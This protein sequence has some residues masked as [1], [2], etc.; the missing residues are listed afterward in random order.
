MANDFEV[1][2]SCDDTNHRQELNFGRMAIELDEFVNEVSL[3]LSVI[4]R[5]LGQAPEVRTPP[6]PDVTPQN[7]PVPKRTPLADRLPSRGSA[8]PEERGTVKPSQTSDSRIQAI[9][10]RLARVNPGRIGDGRG[11]R[12]NE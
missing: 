11:A 1:H 5:Q 9:R 8:P 12:E 4:G 2:D 3:E 7:P 10:N 6:R